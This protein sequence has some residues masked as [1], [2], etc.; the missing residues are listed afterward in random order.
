VLGF[1]LDLL[2]CSLGSRG[3]KSGLVRPRMRYLLIEFDSSPSLMCGVV[4]NMC[5]MDHGVGIAFIRIHVS[6]YY[7]DHDTTHLEIFESILDK[8]YGFTE[9]RRRMA[10]LFESCPESRSGREA[11]GGWRP[12]GILQITRLVEYKCGRRRDGRG[13]TRIC[14]CTTR[15]CCSRPVIRRTAYFFRRIWTCS[16]S[17]LIQARRCRRS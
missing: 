15:L 11:V 14:L 16:C 1:G 17:Q 2:E 9:S 3:L 6:F 7:L 8:S 5:R 13:P 12:P 10:T 4:E